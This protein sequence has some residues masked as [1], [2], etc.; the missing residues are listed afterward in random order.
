[1]SSRF[2]KFSDGVSYLKCKVLLVFTPVF[3]P[4]FSYGYCNDQ[5]QCCDK[6][7]SDIIIYKAKLRDF[8]VDNKLV[9]YK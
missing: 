8:G 7:E 6:L 2:S 4:F 9:W 3:A 5:L 1:M